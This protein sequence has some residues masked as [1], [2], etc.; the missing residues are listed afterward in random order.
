M[1]ATSTLGAVTIR[2][3]G[4]P[5]TGLDTRKVEALLIYLACTGR[6][7]AREVLAEMFWEERTPERALG[8]LRVA[9]SSLRK[10]AAPYLTVDRNTASLDPAAGVW[11]D[12][13][14]LEKK[15]AAGQVEA[16][17]DLYHGE[18]LA[19]FYVRDCPGFEDWA[20]L[21]RERLRRR[22]EN[23]LRDLAA[24]DLEA[25][26]YR[27]GIRHTSRLLAYDGQRGAAVAQYEACCAVLRDELGVEPEAETTRLLQEI[28]AGELA[29]PA[30]RPS[31][32]VVALPPARLARFLQQAWDGHGQVAFVTGEA[33]LGK[34][35]LLDEF[36]RRAMDAYPALLVGSGSCNAY[37]SVGDPYLPFRDILAMLT[38]DLEARWAAGAISSA[39]ARRL[40]HLSK[41]GDVTRVDAYLD[42]RGLRRSNLF[43]QLLQALIE[44]APAGS[45][46]RALFESLSNHLGVRGTVTG[47]QASFTAD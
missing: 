19:G 44:L 24:H 14:E 36:A 15:L 40:M 38:G 30:A 26:D 3:D 9:L 27:A 2:R 16:A 5:L 31:P 46:E 6:T 37:S 20:T 34:T 21:E 41:A 32:P 35:A 10:Y 11:L 39:Q 1:L 45:E 13:A 25:G 12:V 18:F 43:H 22:V 47:R 8:N 29:V 17:L 28:Q 42:A 4:E 33:G 7:H 23:A